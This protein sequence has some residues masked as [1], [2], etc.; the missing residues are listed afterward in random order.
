MGLIHVV[1]LSPFRLGHHLFVLGDTV[2]GRQTRR[3]ELVF[4]TES[5]ADAE[6]LPAIEVW[7]IV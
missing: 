1:I 7:Y 5:A 3:G 4:E 2:E 6:S